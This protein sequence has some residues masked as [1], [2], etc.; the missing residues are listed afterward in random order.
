MA[1]TIHHHCPELQLDMIIYSLFMT[2][3]DIVGRS[4]NY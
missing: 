2:Q 4:N 1:E 3:L